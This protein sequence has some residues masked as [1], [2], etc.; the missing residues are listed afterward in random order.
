MVTSSVVV[1]SF[2]MAKTVGYVGAI[3]STTPGTNRLWFALRSES[4]GGSW[5]K[6]GGKTAWFTMNMDSGDRPSHMAQLT[7][8]LE[9]LRSGAQVRVTHGGAASFERDEPGD[10]FEVDG[11]RINRAGLTF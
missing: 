2:V 9:A 11:V 1:R 6:I 8:L 10:T 7:L 3:E 5:V 4:Q